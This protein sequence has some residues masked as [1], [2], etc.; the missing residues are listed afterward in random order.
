MAERELHA[1]IV[2]SG[3]WLY[4]GLVPSEVWIVRQNF[5]YHHEED[6]ADEPERLNEDGECFSIVIAR[7]GSKIAG[8]P[9]NLSLAEA[10]SAAEQGTPGLIWD[11]H[12]LQKLYG[13]RGHSRTPVTTGM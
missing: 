7:Q 5:E 10:V 2:K 8:G 12:V 13:G 4:D 11:D 3:T 6:Y 1:E 9:E